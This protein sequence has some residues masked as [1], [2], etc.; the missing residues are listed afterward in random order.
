MLPA[1]VP[2]DTRLVS[3]SEDGL[4]F[5]EHGGYFQPRFLFLFRK[6]ALE[7]ETI[8]PRMQHKQCSFIMRLLR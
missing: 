6:Y 1:D 3:A 8:G 5:Q 4:V 2:T 7:I